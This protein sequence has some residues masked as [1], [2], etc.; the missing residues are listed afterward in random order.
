M[1]NYK[2]V[3]SAFHTL[4]RLISTTQDLKSFSVG[5]CRLYKSIFKASKT[6][7]ICKNINFQGYLKIRIEN[8]D[9]TIKKGG[10]SILTRIEKEVLKQEQEIVVN[11]RLIYPIVFN[12]TLG[13]IYIKRHSG[14][15]DFDESEKKWF[16]ALCEEVG[17]CLK[18]ILLYREQH[19]IMINYIKSLSR[20]LNQ[21]VPTSYLHTKVISKLI[22]AMGTALKLSEL[23]TQA[24]EQ[25]SIFHDAGKMQVPSKLLRKQKP[26]TDAEFKLIAKHP[27]KGVELIKNLEAL[28]PA[29][30]IVLHHHER[31]DGKGYPS[32][33]QKN[34]I[35]LGARIL[36]ILDSFDAMF[37][38]R[39]YKKK[40]SL[41]E[42]EAEFKK[43]RGR[44]F[45]P[46]IV[47]VFLRILRRKS[48]L[49]FLKSPVRK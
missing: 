45:D 28:K 29:L 31:Y 12:E 8:K 9:I 42:I 2:T 44:Q 3:F 34:R 33:L 36:A 22:K 26:L 19:K 15:A 47:D 6:V 24:L 46:K 20:L 49:R 4:Y 35:P 32:G 27:R 40:I 18:I 17:I 39:P 13:I 48:V 41:A 23:E 43:Q 5:V 38:G 7:M 16:L 14:L 30:P 11:N 1:K 25:A 21:Y 37:F 10:A